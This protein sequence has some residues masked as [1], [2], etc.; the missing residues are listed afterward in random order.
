MFQNIAGIID[1]ALL[2]LALLPACFISTAGGTAVYSQHCWQLQSCPLK[3][4]AVIQLQAQP[5]VPG[6][7][8][9]SAA[10]LDV[11]PLLRVFLQVPAYEHLSRAIVVCSVPS[12][13]AGL[14]EGAKV[15]C[16]AE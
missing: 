11:L 2:L 1:C 9:H 6:S 13:D 10:H 12:G 15:L 14:V 4:A 3:L 16:R 7:A 8:Q 5:G